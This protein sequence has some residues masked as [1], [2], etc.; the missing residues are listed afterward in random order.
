MTNPTDPIALDYDKP[1]LATLGGM[2]KDDKHRVI[3]EAAHLKMDPKH[4]I[5]PFTPAKEACFSKDPKRYILE[6]DKQKKTIVTPSYFSHLSNFDANISF[7]ETPNFYDYANT[8]SFWVDFAAVL[9]GGG[10]FRTG[11][12]QEE[13]MCMEMP[14]LANAAAITTK[15]MN[16]RDPYGTK[17]VLDGSPTPI[18]IKGLNRVMHIPANVN[19]QSIDTWTI[20]ELKDEIAKWMLPKPQSQINVLAM[21]AP[22]LPNDRP[23]LPSSRAYD[24]DTQ[25]DLFNTFVAG[26]ELAVEQSAKGVLINTGRI[27]CGVFNHDPRI[28][29]V[30][31]V[32]AAKFVGVNLMLWG[33]NHSDSINNNVYRA[34][35]CINELM[36]DM[37]R[38]QDKSISTLLHSAQQKMEGWI[39]PK[40][41]DPVD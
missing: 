25:M 33:Y 18:V 11:F 40:P 26:F 5:T 16:C 23:K 34:R 12:A 32:F 35:A 30:L 8:A 6:L 28:V 9:L 36:G 13:V 17:G 41:I 1:L 39:R 31:Q 19:R 38:S 10:V 20:A 4:P 27:G 7:G 29:Y 24:L 14:D 2:P 21:A 3:L 37:A 15:P 22:E